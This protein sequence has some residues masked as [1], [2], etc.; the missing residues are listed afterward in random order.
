VDTIYID[1]DTGTDVE[2]ATGTESQP[3]KSLAYAYIQHGGSEGKTYQSRSSETGSVS[4]D[5]DPAERLLWKEPAKSAVKKAQG[6]LDAH[7]KKLLKQQQ[8]ASQEEEKEKLRL[9]NLED[10][11]KIILKEDPSLPKAVKITI[12]RKDID[13]GRLSQICLL[14]VVIQLE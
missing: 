2:S 11:K 6:A 7:K 13:L 5:G 3:Y 1:T 10:A 4:A 12:G 8:A 9:K 14:A